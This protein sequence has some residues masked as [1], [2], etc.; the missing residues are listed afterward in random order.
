LVANPL[1][2]DTPRIQ[3]IS[4]NYEGLPV[5]LGTHAQTVTIIGAGNQYTAQA[6]PALNKLGSVT[7]A[8][9]AKA[10]SV[11]IGKMTLTLSPEAV[12]AE[13]LLKPIRAARVLIRV[14]YSD[15][16]ETVKFYE[17]SVRDLAYSGGEYILTIQDPLELADVSVPRQKWQTWSSA[18]AYLSGT[19][20]TYG[21]KSYLALSNTTGQIPTSFPLV[22]QDAGTVWIDIVYAANTHL[23][24]VVSDILTNQVNIPSERID[25][26]SIDAVKAKY[27]NRKTG[28]RIISNP[29]PALGMLS[30]L[31]WLL[32]SFW[33]QRDGRMALIPEADANSVP[34][35]HL[36]PDDISEGL[37]Y[38]RGIAELKNECLILTQYTGS[39]AGTEQFTNA[40]AYVDANSVLTYGINAVHQFNDKWNLPTAELNTIAA[41]FVTRW[42]DGRRIIRVRASMIAIPIETGDVVELR[43]AQLPTADITRLRAIV[44]ESNINWQSQTITLTLMEI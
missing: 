15:V 13:L 37:E 22:W 11:M 23:C 44:M 20:V 26:G 8:L 10:K 16:T 36:T 4:V 25:F 7:S 34:D 17:G 31:A 18:T 40:I 1:R 24:D 28:G 12:V 2:D 42:K 21:N 3:S 39:G 33:G 5:V 43:S 38:R 27:P 6:I 30:D 29:E 19:T 41:R 9:D 35:A 14:G 32:E